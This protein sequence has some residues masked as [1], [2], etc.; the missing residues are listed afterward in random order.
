MVELVNRA[1][2]TAT[3]DQEKQQLIDDYL[4]PSKPIYSNWKNGLEVVLEEFVRDNCAEIVDYDI[5]RRR[6]TPLP[7]YHPPN[8]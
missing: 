7:D 6:F 1:V 2:L 5:E 3:N 4:F 8:E